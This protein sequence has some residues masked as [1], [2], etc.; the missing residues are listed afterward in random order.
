MTKINPLSDISGAL[1][2]QHTIVNTN[3]ELVEEAFNN[4]LSRDGSAPN[5]MEADFD[6]DNNDILNVKNLYASGLVLDGVAF[7][8]PEVSNLSSWGT[9]YDYG[10]Q[11][12][13]ELLQD[14]T[15][16]LQALLD[17]VRD[18]WTTVGG[19]VYNG[20]F[21]VLADLAG[22]KWRCDGPLGFI[23]VGQP[24][25]VI[26]NGTIWSKAVG[27]AAF[28]LVGSNDVL[29]S[30]IN[31]YGDAISSPAVGFLLA[32]SKDKSLVAAS[33]HK[34]HLCSSQG[35][36]SHAGYLNVASEVSELI[37]SK[38]FNRYD[39]PNAVAVAC[40]DH[41]SVLEDNLGG[42]TPSLAPIQTAGDGLKSNILHQ[43]SAVSATRQF[44][45]NVSVT[46][47]T[48]GSDPTVQCASGSLAASG[49]SNGKEVVFWYANG[50]TEIRGQ[51][52]TVASIDTVN[53]TFVASGIDTSGYTALTSGFV[54]NRTGPAML[55]SGCDSLTID[56]SY[57]V[58][59]G[60]CAI[61]MDLNYGTMRD[62]DIRIGAE[63]H[64]ESFIRF[65]ENASTRRVVQ[66]GRISD[67]SK[68]QDY[69]NAIFENSGGGGIQ[70]QDM[71]I[72]VTNEGTVPPG[73]LFSTPG[74]I[75]LVDCD[76]AVPLAAAL[77]PA[78][79]YDANGYQVVDSA[80][81]RT[82]KRIDYRPI[83]FAG[84][85]TFERLDGGLIAARFKAQEESS[86]SEP[87]VDVFKD[88]TT[89]ANAD[90]LGRIRFLGNN[91][92]DE[93]TLFASIASE[94]VNIA[95]GSEEGLLNFFVK[96]AGAEILGGSV[97]ADGVHSQGF[98]VMP[99][100]S[101][102]TSQMTDASDDINTVDKYEGK[103]VFN[104]VS[105]R[106]VWAVGSGT[107]DVWVYADGTTAHTPS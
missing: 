89:P 63:A 104:S 76:I 87:Y 74:S 2:N 24:G 31:I 22:K 80:F 71:S 48:I 75:Q 82:P 36:F 26:R 14:N 96:S 50:M 11:P 77:H 106:P 67:L 28:S 16:Y 103:Q 18:S 51:R 5:N 93:E 33:R 66:G 94:S 25:A 19:D 40:I 98:R 101:R 37:G 55:L 92:A 35:Y 7:S 44:S 29:L 6:M 45:V 56:R 54:C 97:E 95:D 107:T 68:A 27:D 88:S 1:P 79:D 85:P 34:L 72:K 61:L 39:S 59:F 46:G 81:D 4:T 73:G 23:E 58:S 69:A 10:A 3:F 65:N 9:P 83:T 41:Y 12:G 90:A 91:D 64:P 70:F 102:I 60:N 21:A 84:N 49:W 20:H 38:F 57:I 43:W 17:A 47:I 8:I 15:V 30:G 99:F 52:C 100:I 105:N 78:S 62:F 13:M 42:F 32:R 53:D 86:S